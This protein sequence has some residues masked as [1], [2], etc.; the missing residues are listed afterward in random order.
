MLHGISFTVHPSEKI[1]VV[2]RTGSGALTFTHVSCT[3]TDPFLGKSTLA[4]SLL[5][6]VEP[7]GGEIMYVCPLSTVFR[8]DSSRRIDG[9]NISSIGLDDLRT[10]VVGCDMPIRQVQSLTSIL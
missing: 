3:V 9:V 5:R 7:C 1:G 8:F 4:L 6:I 10:R 2:G